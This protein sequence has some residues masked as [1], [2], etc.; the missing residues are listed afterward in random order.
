MPIVRCMLIV[1]MLYNSANSVHLRMTGIGSGSTAGFSAQTPHPVTNPA[2]ISH[3]PTRTEPDS[4]QLTS[5]L[6]PPRVC[7]VIGDCVSSGRSHP[8]PATVGAPGM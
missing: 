6:L 4:G 1:N 5:A 3:S 2:I 7:C 8:N